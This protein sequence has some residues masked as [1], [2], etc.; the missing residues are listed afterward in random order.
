M[1]EPAPE[2]PDSDE[3]SGPEIPYNLYVQTFY[4][5]DKYEAFDVRKATDTALKGWGVD[6]FI[7]QEAEY[8]EGD[9]DNVPTVLT[10][11]YELAA[12]V[13]IFVERK[14]GGSRFELDVTDDIHIVAIL[15]YLP[16]QMEPEHIAND[17]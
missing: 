17:L 2:L 9:P 10:V 4:P 16:S 5:A 7:S 8:V 1:V 15:D 14:A 3:W 11:V 13:A 6:I 12:P